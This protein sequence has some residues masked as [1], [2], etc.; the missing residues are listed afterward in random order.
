ME[1]LQTGW[2]KYARTGP[3]DLSRQMSPWCCE[4]EPWL[5]TPWRRLWMVEK[6]RS[7]GDGGGTWLLVADGCGTNNPLSFVSYETI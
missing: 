3:W 2:K 6:E 7:G 4:R 5:S 1:R